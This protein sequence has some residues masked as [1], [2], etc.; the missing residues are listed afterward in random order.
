MS[1]DL[2]AWEDDGMVSTGRTRRLRNGAAVVFIVMAVGAEGEE[3]GALA[4]GKRQLAKAERM[5]RARLSPPQ[6]VQASQT[7]D[8]NIPAKPLLP[9]LAD[10]TAA[11]R[12]QVVRPDAEAVSGTSQSVSGTFTAA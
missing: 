8:F 12:I 1:T 4:A 9:A 2:D 11:A 5:A 10:F 3:V 6:L 7:D